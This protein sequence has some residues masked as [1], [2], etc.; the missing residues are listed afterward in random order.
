MDVRLV[1][2]VATSGSSPLHRASPRTKAAAAA[3]VIASAAVT[4]NLFVC[5][6]VAL[7]VVAAAVLSRIPLRPYLSL[8]GYPAVFAALFAW[9]SA[10]DA[11]SGALI[12]SKAVTAAL[13]VV[14][15]LFTTPYPQ[16]FASLQRTLPG[17]VG[18]ALFMTYRAIFVL[19]EKLDDLIVAARLRSGAGRHPIRSARATV[20]ALGNLVLYAFDLAQREYDI[21]ALRGY[22]GRLA[23]PVR[24][25]AAPAVD[26][27]ALAAGTAALAAALAWR[28]AWRDLLPYSWMPLA[29]AAAL[30]VAALVVRFAR[31]GGTRHA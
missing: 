23:V 31:S 10:P 2:T 25:S 21:L 22:S 28:V 14:L 7:A 18:D 15:L 1:D 8:A 19:G 30:L 3:L 13:A 29:A 12:V 16:V 17:L 6:G 11:L 20:R 5:T 26:A 27:L 4:T 24:R 9:A